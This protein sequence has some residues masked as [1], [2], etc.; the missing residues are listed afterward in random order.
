MP[1]LTKQ[2]KFYIKIIDVLDQSD[3]PFMIGGS[4]AYMHHTKTIRPT[5]DIDI[6]CIPTDVSRV[7]RAFR[8]AGMK[9]ELTYKKW[10]GKVYD[11]DNFADIVFRSANGKHVVTK[12]WM[13]RS[14]AGVLFGRKIRMKSPEDVILTKLYVMGRDC[15]HGHDVYK[16]IKALGKKL[17]WHMI[18]RES[19]VDWQILYAHTLFFDY[20]FPNDREKIPSWLRAE[21]QKKAAKKGGGG[22]FRG[23]MLSMVDYSTPKQIAALHNHPKK[24]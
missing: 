22:S 14:E 13:V 3:V 1:K 20:V 23:K 4:Y 19:K 21:M 10:L 18:W 6:F 8:I 17:D 9:T 16:L 7:M 24:A 12:K 11:D 2:E 5:K 15:F